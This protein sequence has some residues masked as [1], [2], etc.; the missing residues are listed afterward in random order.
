MGDWK[1][2]FRYLAV[3]VKFS[4]PFKGV[5]AGETAM[6]PQ[7][8]DRLLLALNSVRLKKIAIG[9]DR[10]GNDYIEAMSQ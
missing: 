1:K 10:T 8:H 4:S 9:R 2:D 7:D 6:I 3:P 5:N